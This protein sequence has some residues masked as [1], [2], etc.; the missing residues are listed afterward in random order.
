MRQCQ[1]KADVKYVSLLMQHFKMSL[2]RLESVGSK[3][4]KQ[5]KNVRNVINILIFFMFLL[6]IAAGKAK[7][8][9]IYS[10]VVQD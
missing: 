2:G 6:K 5:L 7:K 1:G 10:Y 8:N 9:S 3:F 4:S